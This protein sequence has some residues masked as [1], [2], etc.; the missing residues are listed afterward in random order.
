MECVLNVTEILVYL[1]LSA[2]C[3]V[4]HY[5]DDCVSGCTRKNTSVASPLGVRCDGFQLLKS[6]NWRSAQT[7]LRDVTEGVSTLFVIVQ[8]LFFKSKA[9]TCHPRRTVL[10]FTITYKRLASVCTGYKV[11]KRSC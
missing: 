7:C 8:P 11:H 6:C 3:F 4:A 10:G 1:V 5:T 9:D 2:E